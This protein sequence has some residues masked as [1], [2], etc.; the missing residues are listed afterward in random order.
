MKKLTTLLAVMFAATLAYAGDKDKDK[1]TTK[2]IKSDVKA[3][4]KDAK[5][6]AKETK[7]EIKSEAKET[8]AEVKA[9]LKSAK[10]HDVEGEIV[11]VDS[12]KN[13]ITIKTTK[14]EST[15]PVEGKAQTSLKD[16][17]PG[18]KVTVTCRDDDK[19]AHK[20][21]TE[22]KSGTS[23]TTTTAPAKKTE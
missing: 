7:S 20:A 17:K 12:A 19:G 14:G 21:V 4:A 11:S 18:Q 15:A 5:A 6:E 13:T 22:I 9:D 10:T 8:K 3:A 23:T 16:L 1:D 2:E